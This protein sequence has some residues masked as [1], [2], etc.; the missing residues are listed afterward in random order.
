MTVAGIT[1]CA[2]LAI[3]RHRLQCIALQLRPS[4]FEPCHSRICTCHGLLQ[5][6][7]LEYACLFL[8]GPSR[9]PLKPVVAAAPA[10]RS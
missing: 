5:R 8:T 6:L 3:L 7:C 10:G 2:V 9:H 4:G 1:D